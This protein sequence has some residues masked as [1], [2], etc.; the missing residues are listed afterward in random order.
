MYWIDWV[1][2]IAMGY[3]LITGW[4]NG[5]VRS[6]LNVAALGAAFILGP[7]LRPAALQLIEL[8]MTGDPLLKSWFATAV[9]YGS[10][11]VGLSILGIIWSRFLAKGVIKTSDKVAGLVLGGVLSLIVVTVPLALILA[12]PALATAPVVQRSMAQSKLLPFIRPVAPMLQG[13]AYGFLHPAKTPAIP[14][15]PSQAAKPSQ[16][17]KPKATQPA[18]PK[19]A[20]PAKPKTGK[21]HG[22][23]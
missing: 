21:P 5:L 13:L 8:V 14:S 23:P 3:G 19:S 9:A 10:V 17:E 7:V 22:H 20:P 11:Y 15:K 1:I 16:A 4:S 2:V 12:V 18:K 6:L